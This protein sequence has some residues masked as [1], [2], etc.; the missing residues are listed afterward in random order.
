[1]PKQ[2]RCVFPQLQQHSVPARIAALI[3]PTWL[4]NLFT[5]T[6]SC[7]LRGKA[8]F[9]TENKNRETA[10]TPNLCIISN[11]LI[12]LKNYRLESIA[13]LPVQWKKEGSLK[14]PTVVISCAATNI[15]RN[16]CYGWAAKPGSRGAPL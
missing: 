14:Q 5:L 4:Y 11:I 16:H 3:F 8:V 1:M 2:T 12:S 13:Q 10:R 9:G 7:V 6:T 15:S